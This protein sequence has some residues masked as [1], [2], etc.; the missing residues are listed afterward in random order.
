VSEKETSKDAPIAEIL[1]VQDEKI[2]K[3]VEEVDRFFKSIHTDVEDWKFAMQDGGDGTRIFVRFQLHIKTSG[4]ASH[5]K[6][7]KVDVRTSAETVPIESVL[8]APEVPP[9][10]QIREETTGAAASG[11]LE[12]VPRADPDLASFVEAWKRKRANGPQL[13]F[14]RPGAPLVDPP[15]EVKRR[16]RRRAVA[17]RR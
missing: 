11:D 15:L 2:R 17:A 14:H 13:E 8:S 1:G 7:T 3:V 12:A 9:S 10:P 4:A 5:P 16:T 6:G